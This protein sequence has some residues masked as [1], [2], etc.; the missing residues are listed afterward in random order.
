[1]AS[2]SKG[3][4]GKEERQDRLDRSCRSKM[5]I[6][7]GLI[8][9]QECAEDRVLCTNWLS[10]LSCS[11][12]AEAK[13]RDYL[14]D[15]MM[16]QLRQGKLSE[17][18][19]THVN[20]RTDLHLLLDEEGRQRLSRS[21]EPQME[22]P[23]K[24]I[25]DRRTS[26]FFWRQRVK[27]LASLEEQYR[28]EEQERWLHELMVDTAIKEAGVQVELPV[29]V[30]AP[31]GEDDVLDPA[32]Q[33]QENKERRGRERLRYLDQ[34]LQNVT[35]RRQSDLQRRAEVRQLREQHLHEQQLKVKERHEHE[36]KLMIKRREA[37]SPRSLSQSK[38]GTK[39]L[40][41]E[42]EAEIKGVDVEPTKEVINFKPE[43]EKEARKL[44]KCKACH[45]VTS[46][47][48]EQQAVLR[49]EN[50]KKKVLAYEELKQYHR[51][52]ALAERERLEMEQLNR[53]KAEQEA[54]QG[55]SI[56]GRDGFN[57]RKKQGEERKTTPSGERDQKHVEKLEEREDALEE[58]ERRSRQEP[59]REFQKPL[60]K[61]RNQKRKPEEF[62]KNEEPQ[63]EPEEEKE[64]TLQRNSPRQLEKNRKLEARNIEDF[65]YDY[66]NFREKQLMQ[67]WIDLRER[68]EVPPGGL[69]PAQEK[70]RR[71]K[72]RRA[73]IKFLK[74]ATEHTELISREVLKKTKSRMSFL[75]GND[76]PKE[77]EEEPRES[78][79]RDMEELPPGDRKSEQSI[80][81]ITLRQA[82]E[83]FLAK[84]EE[85]YLKREPQKVQS[86]SKKIQ[87]NEDLL[88]KQISDRYQEHLAKEKVAFAQNM[89][90]FTDCWQ[91]SQENGKQA[92]VI[93][94]KCMQELQDTE[95]AL[96]RIS[97]RGEDL[98]TA[99]LKDDG[100]PEDSDSKTPRYQAGSNYQYPLP[101]DTDSNEESPQWDT[102]RS[103]R[104]V[105]EQ[106]KARRS[107]PLK[108]LYK[109]KLWRASSSRIN[110]EVSR[111]YRDDSFVSYCTETGRKRY[112]YIRRSARTIREKRKPLNRQTFRQLLKG[113]GSNERSPSILISHNRILQRKLSAAKK[114]AL[115]KYIRK[116]LMLEAGR[117]ID[118]LLY[119]KAQ[120]PR[121]T[122]PPR[123]TF[124]L[125]ID[126]LLQDVEDVSSHVLEAIKHAD[127]Q[128]EAQL[129]SL[130]EKQN[131]PQYRQNYEQVRDLFL[132][133]HLVSDLL[134]DCCDLDPNLSKILRRIDQLYK[135]WKDFRL[136]L[137]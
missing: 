121:S 16:R 30:P 8:R 136:G 43:P 60:E 17:P 33:R 26:P 137:K 134:N 24:L 114:I 34:G 56:G 118:R 109:R 15:Q 2:K 22:V 62:Q 135:R 28:R 128:L 90:L 48:R 9:K 59:P 68:Y 13:A 6:I 21:S 72:E 83:S 18:F 97:P 77:R 47:S 115:D 122:T 64:K 27:H 133:Q 5:S 3:V 69:S 96:Q 29:P 11:S 93:R 126:S 100:S 23:Q 130:L 44:M 40:A 49:A 111:Q 132:R 63:K 57:G 131:A 107:Y 1:M 88:T 123:H 50:I 46:E 124:Q 52:Q 75:P 31:Q 92:D 119:E 70:E 108:V 79:R 45:S 78:E 127:G 12:K 87:K 120:S 82:H 91:R 54:E 41:P 95:A 73:K 99:A 7:R 101:S 51:K 65:K 104:A 61:E 80:S 105:N 85:M 106:S 37:H 94:G 113:S 67:K 125:L 32:R 4:A 39:E 58:S 76:L 35:E 66:F 110:E 36:R 71:K 84:A 86:C 55:R 89:D 129:E 102:Y 14:L 42:V 112:P 103:Y 53:K 20:C 117:L 19:T 10:F 98:T 25:R 74:E 38:Q 81:K 116:N